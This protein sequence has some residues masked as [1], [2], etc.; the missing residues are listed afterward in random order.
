MMEAY[1]DLALDYWNNG[2][3]WFEMWV[4]NPDHPE[5]F[6]FADKLCNISIELMEQLDSGGI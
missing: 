2:F 5:Y 4:N 6:R 3:S 1:Y